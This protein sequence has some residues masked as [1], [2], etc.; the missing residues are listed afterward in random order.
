M[1]AT[2]L[3]PGAFRQ[4]AWITNDLDRAMAAFAADYGVPR[5]L[6]LRNF[7]LL[8]GPGTYADVHIALAVRGGVELELIQPLGGDDHV[9]RQSSHSG[10]RATNSLPSHLLQAGIGRQRWRPCATRPKQRAARSCFMARP[11]PARPISTSTTAPRLAITS[12]ISTTRR[13]ICCS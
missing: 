4:V 3:F 6:E 11:R 1:D 13:L 8:T 5:W 2:G 12:S 10:P 7:K 9:Y